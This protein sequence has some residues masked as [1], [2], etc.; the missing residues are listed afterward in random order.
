MKK[1]KRQKEFLF[2]KQFLFITQQPRV[3]R[4]WCQTKPSLSLPSFVTPVGGIMPFLNNL[5]Y[6]KERQVPA[7]LR[8]PDEWLAI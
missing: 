1:K 5:A 7:V 4:N 8:D 6:T 2:I 3:Q